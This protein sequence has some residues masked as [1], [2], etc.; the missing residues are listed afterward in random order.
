VGGRRARAARPDA[1][2]GGDRLAGVQGDQ[3][4]S[5]GEA[6]R[7]AGHRLDTQAAPALRLGLGVAGVELE[8]PVALVDPEPYGVAVGRGEGERRSPK[9]VA[10]VVTVRPPSSSW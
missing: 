10:V 2:A 8:I 7:W 4:L 3:V 5:G 1:P 9:L 6:V